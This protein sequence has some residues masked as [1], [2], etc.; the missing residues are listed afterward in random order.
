[1]QDDHK[2]SMGSESD[3]V[4]GFIAE[5]HAFDVRLVPLLAALDGGQA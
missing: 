2:L 3:A 5:T 1:M 4:N